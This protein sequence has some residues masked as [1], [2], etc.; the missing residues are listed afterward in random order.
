[1]SLQQTESRDFT[2]LMWSLTAFEES[3][4]TVY[5]TTQVVKPLHCSV[6]LFALDFI[7]SKCLKCKLKSDP[8]VF[9]AIDFLL[10]NV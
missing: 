2:L 5:F 6:S 9:E 3:C 4:K 8:E 1:M 10:E 7:G